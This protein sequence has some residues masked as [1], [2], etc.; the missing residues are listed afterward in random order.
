M[1]RYKFTDIVSTSSMTEISRGHLNSFFNS[2]NSEPKCASKCKTI[3]SSSSKSSSSKPTT[4]TN[5]CSSSS[6]SSSS[7]STSC[8]KNKSHKSHKHKS[9]NKSA[10]CKSKHVKST[11]TTT[12][13][14][15]GSCPSS[16]SSSCPS[17]SSS[18]CPSSS[19]S[20]CPSSSCSSSCPSSSWPRGMTAGCTA[21]FSN[22]SDSSCNP[23]KVNCSAYALKC[24]T[25]KSLGGTILIPGPQGPSSGSLANFSGINNPGTTITSPTIYFSTVNYVNITPSQTINTNDTFTFNLPGKYLFQYNVYV[26]S[27]VGSSIEFF[28][29]V[30]GI[31]SSSFGNQH[32]T[33]HSNYG[34]SI[35]QDM[36]MGDFIALSIVGTGLWN[37][38][39]L[40]II[41][42]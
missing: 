15:S 17:S 41:K 31:S 36:A 11:Y 26:L 9:S 1:S 22:S 33:S 18:S 34:C 37:F 10:N 25:Y 40:T 24:N 12:N 5:S 42:L 16:S 13:S 14:S 19:S 32:I 38:A 30:N 28:G 20:S 3:K 4:S 2:S 23:C 6:S 39:S 21:G 7:S 35:I 29:K 8:K 27:Q